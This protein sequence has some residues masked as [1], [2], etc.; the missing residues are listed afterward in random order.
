[1]SNGTTMLKN[2][3]HSFK[4]RNHLTWDFGVGCAILLAVVVLLGWLIDESAEPKVDTV[5]FR[6]YPGLLVAMAS[7][8]FGATFS[9]LVKYRTRAAQ[10]SEDDLQAALAWYTLITR[11]SVGLGASAVL[12]FFFESGLLNGTLWPNLAQLKFE[13]S[14]V[15]SGNASAVVPNKDWCLLVIWTFLAGFSESFVP[16]ILTQTETKVAKT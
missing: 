15:G 13:I 1:M 5:L 10:G 3:L 2:G 9:M 6:S 11:A 7:G 12:Y 4:T 8:L 14:P 16:N